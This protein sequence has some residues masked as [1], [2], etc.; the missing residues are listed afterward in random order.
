MGVVGVGG[1]S[2]LSIGGTLR[3]GDAV[4]TALC[5]NNPETLRYKGD[6]Y[7]IPENRRFLDYNDLIACSEVDAVSNVTPNNVHLEVMLAVLR[8]GKPLMTE[9]PMTLDAAEA[10]TALAAAREAGVP[11]MLG[12]TYRFYPAMRYARHIVRSGELGEIRHVYAQYKQAGGTNE[13]APRVWRYNKAL[14]GTGALGD[15]GSHALDMARFVT[16]AEFTSVSAELGTFVKRRPSLG[17]YKAVYED[18][19]R[20]F[21][22][23]S[24]EIHWEEVDVDDYSHMHLQ[25][26]NGAAAA[27]EITRFGYGRGNY[28][29][30]EIQGSK[31]ALVYENDADSDHQAKLYACIG[32][33]FGMSHAYSRIDIPQ[34]FTVD[35]T[36]CFF[37]LIHG[38]A[39]D[40]VPT[41]EDGYR[42]MLAL[43][44]CV[45]SHEEGRRIPLKG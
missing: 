7:G 36:Q 17:D 34:Q 27:F 26:D 43:D 6:L 22:R 14:T 29:R 32:P 11:V 24:E 3:S 12:F 8:A 28:Q 40:M 9:K 41:I 4:L 18:G 37:D 23:V 19:G 44:A 2:A 20:R 10:E 15:L 13:N 45:R 39:D 21:E 33:S 16:G 31:G 1:H 38:S 30:L 25:M 5:D 35:E 42:N